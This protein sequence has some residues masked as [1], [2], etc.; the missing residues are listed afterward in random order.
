MVRQRPE[1]KSQMC[2]IG[3]GMN[4]ECRGMYVEADRGRVKMGVNPRRMQRR[5]LLVG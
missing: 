2:D 5:G 1:L 4:Y 3:I